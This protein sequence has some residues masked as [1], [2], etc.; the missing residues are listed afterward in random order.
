MLPISITHLPTMQQ[1]PDDFLNLYVANF[2]N[3]ARTLDVQQLTGPPASF[4]TAVTLLGRLPTSFSTV[5]LPIQRPPISSAAA[6]LPPA[7]PPASLTTITG[8]PTSGPSPR[9]TRTGPCQWYNETLVPTCIKDM[10]HRPIW[11]SGEPASVVPQLY[12]GTLL[13]CL[14]LSIN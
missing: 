12:V 11:S 1:T 8:S 5:V 7:G 13:Q 2:V 4:S 3:Y 9:T 6:V 14:Y 10:C